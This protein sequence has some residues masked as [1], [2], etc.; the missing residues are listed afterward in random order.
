V[1][2]S[3]SIEVPVDLHDDGKGDFQKEQSSFILLDN[4]IAILERINVS[5][6]CW[7]SVFTAAHAVPRCS[8]VN[9][10]TMPVGL[11]EL[12]TFLQYL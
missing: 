5:A 6:L 1:V 10:V 12:T 4:F 9:V 11:K 3:I 8:A 2:G 7:T